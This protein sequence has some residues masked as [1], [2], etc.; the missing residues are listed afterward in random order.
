MPQDVIDRVNTLGRRSHAANTLTFAW[1]DGTP[2]VNDAP[3]DDA[4]D[5]TYQPDDDDDDFSDDGSHDEVSVAGVNHDKDKENKL[6]NENKQDEPND[7]HENNNVMAEE[8]ADVAEEA[9]D[10]VE[11]AADNAQEGNNEEH[12]DGNKAAI[13]L[14]DEDEA[15]IISDD[16]DDPSKS[17]GVDDNDTDDDSSE[18]AG[19]D[20]DPSEGTNETEN[21]V[22]TWAEP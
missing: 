18:S 9:D 1:S 14:E 11:E 20:Y 2:I 6:D 19:V 15:P 17:A 16:E 5:A 12:V 10:I 22:V 8:A 7:K 3:D 21:T 4:D 13:D